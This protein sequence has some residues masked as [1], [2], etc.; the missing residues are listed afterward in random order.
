[1]N[2]PAIHALIQ[3]ANKVPFSLAAFQDRK[4]RCCEPQ[5]QTRRWIIHGPPWGW[6]GLCVPACCLA[7]PLERE[8]RAADCCCPLGSTSSLA[9]VGEEVPWR[10]SSLCRSL[11]PGS[12]PLGRVSSRWGWAWKMAPGECVDRCTLSRWNRTYKGKTKPGL[13]LHGPPSPMATPGSRVGLEGT[14]RCHFY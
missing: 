12:P 14:H 2:P 4:R 3:P 11:D 7:L 10:T 8:H 5:A 1:M 6:G 9:L 13:P